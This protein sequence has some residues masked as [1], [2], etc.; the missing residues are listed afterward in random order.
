[1]VS[2][3]SG[4]AFPGPAGGAGVPA[5]DGVL[6]VAARR[7]GST[8]VASS[9]NGSGRSP[10]SKALQGERP[11]ECV[12]PFLA[13]E[14][15][16]RSVLYTANPIEALN[17]QLRRAVKTK[18][19]FPTEDAVRKLLYPPSTMPFPNG[20]EPHAGRKSCLPSRS[21]SDTAYPT[22]RLHS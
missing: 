5:E 14:P 4:E 11:G 8:L 12:I 3:G 22:N 7:P 20:P 10:G 13:F 1:M 16:V 2:A 15:E 18:G 6:G 19:H 17:R 9:G 21:S